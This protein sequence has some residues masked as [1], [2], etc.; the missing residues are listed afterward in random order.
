MGEKEYSGERRATQHRGRESRYLL[1]DA[2]GFTSGQS[3]TGNHINNAPGFKILLLNAESLTR[4]TL[5]DER[6]DLA[7]ITETCIKEEG[8]G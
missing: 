3:D 7:G 5:L 8:W 4:N 2:S 1:T 6:A